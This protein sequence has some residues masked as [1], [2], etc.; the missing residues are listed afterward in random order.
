MGDLNNALREAKHSGRVQT[1]VLSGE[2][3]KNA[4]L[5]PLK[6]SSFNAHLICTSETND[7]VFHSHNFPEIY[8]AIKG[9]IILHLLEQG[10]IREKFINQNDFYIYGGGPH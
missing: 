4:V 1:I 5:I 7:K 2:I 10:E 9:K 6:K 3:R 8:Y